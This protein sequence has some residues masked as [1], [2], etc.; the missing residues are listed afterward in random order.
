MSNAEEAIATSLE[1]IQYGESS[2]ICLFFAPEKKATPPDNLGI[3]SIQ[4][5]Q[6]KQVTQILFKVGEGEDITKYFKPT[7]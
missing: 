7:P 2:K 6:L 4:F 1:L 3:P 5:D